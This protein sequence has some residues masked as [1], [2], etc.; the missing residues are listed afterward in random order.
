MSPLEVLID[1]TKVPSHHATSHTSISTDLVAF[2]AS[3]TST[4]YNTQ[5][6]RELARQRALAQT[7]RPQRDTTWACGPKPSKPRLLEP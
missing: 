1:S 5:V 2:L 7:N 4:A 3:L 6:V